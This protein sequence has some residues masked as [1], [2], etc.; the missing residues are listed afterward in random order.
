MV[1]CHVCYMCYKRFDIIILTEIGPRNTTTVQN[2]INEYNFYY[3]ISESNFY[4]RVGIYVHNSI[5]DVCVMDELKI[6]KSCH[7]PSCENEIIF[8]KFTYCRKDFIVCGIYRHPNGNVKHF[9]SDLEVSLNKISDGISA[10][11]AGDIN[12]DIIKYN[13]EETVH[14]LTT[15]L[16]CRLLPY[17]TLPIRI[18]QYSTTCIDHIF[19]K[20]SKRSRTMYSYII[21]GML[22]C[23]IT[24]HLPCFVSLKCIDY[25]N[26]N[27]ISKVRLYGKRNC[28]RFVEMM[29]T[30]QWE[31]YH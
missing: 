12:I 22:Y 21:A 31:I 6:G 4:G 23:H 9:V 18:T 5:V 16:S 24:D 29:T 8:L 26:M 11:F 28:Q 25:I 2:I 7:C 15:L 1:S 3:V 27:E 10:I 30:K 13:K 20:L 19:V 17:V 14:Y